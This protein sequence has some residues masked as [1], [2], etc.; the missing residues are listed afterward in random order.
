MELILEIL[1][2]L[3]FEGSISA[4]GDKKVP[5]VLRILAGIV[6]FVVM[7]GAIALCLFVGIEGKN[8]IILVVGVI[9]L[10]ATV[11]LLFKAFRKHR[12]R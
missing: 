5:L 10:V 7:G 1:F 6:I 11:F 8:W 9:L 12:A 4:V 2:E 3:I